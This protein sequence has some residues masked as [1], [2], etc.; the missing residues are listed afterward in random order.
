MICGLS[1]V[2]L[3]AGAFTDVPAGSTYAQAV[4][5]LQDRGLMGG[6]GA[7]Q[8]AP[9]AP[10]TLAEL[11]T[12]LGRIA[13]ADPTERDLPQ[14]IQADGWSGGYMAWA[15]D[16]HLVS[17]DRIGQY[18]ALS[19]PELDGILSAF[20]SMQGRNRVN[21]SAAGS[22]V[23]RG[24]AA[25]ALAQLVGYPAP[26]SISLESVFLPAGELVGYR[27][28]S[29][30][31]FKGIPYATAERFQS[32]EPV[33]A[34]DGGRKM[35]LAFG[36]V[37]PQ[38]ATRNGTASVNGVEI[39]TPSNDTADMVANETCQY[40]N[41]WTDD[42]TANKP[43]VVFFHGGGY[44]SGASSELS[45]YT[46]EYFAGVEDAVFVS[47]NH[48]PNVLG[49]LD[50]SEYG[51][52]Y[53]RSTVAGLEDCV[54]ALQW[55]HDNIAQF[56][57]DPNNVTIVGQ[58]GGGGKVNALAC[59]PETAELFDKVVCMSG[60]YTFSDA[61]STRAAT[62]RLVE[63]LGL[64]EDEVIPTLTSMTY[65][66]LSAACS[67]A[68]I[69][70]SPSYGNSLFPAPLLNE[71]GTLNE[72]AA[73]RQWMIG[74]VYGDHSGSNGP[75]LQRGQED[76]YLPDISDEEAMERLTERYGDNAQE[77]ARLWQAAYPGHQLAEALFINTTDSWG[78]GRLIS[79]TDYGE[80][81]LK[82]FSDNGVDVYNYL[83]AY[84]MPLFGGVT[85][86]HTTDM[87]FWF[88]TL[89]EVD[90]M[91]RGD[92]ANA[93]RVSRQMAD[94][95]AAFAATGDPSTPSL[96]WTP[97]TNASH[98]TMVFDVNSECKTAY[99]EAFENLLLA[100]LPD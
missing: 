10:I 71:D 15:A 59:M 91:V 90:Y 7:G 1:P 23:T 6:R 40:L 14:G 92:E 9:S 27:E 31:N 75:A 48:R 12:V 57:G 67:A 39:L 47:V 58:S 76:R 20:C 56:G 87:G 17:L 73:R 2:S 16:N 26:E 51:E 93:C 63:S 36:P 85:M 8:F 96:E 5:T 69:G 46:G 86:A 70:G 95:L 62:Q 97:Y 11:V 24:E 65:D 79:A 88:Y 33:T 82:T 25:V 61:A 60:M 34:Y 81:L 32:P 64:S 29:V 52:A 45:T 68:G 53:E 21:A 55:V 50:L 42:L 77:L 66:E 83:V 4:Q 35:A 89:D 100:S 74:T 54:C 80:P 84:R 22:Q 38:N 37:S 28:G 94:A 3:A 43:V 78:R 44:S 13:S 41:V 72:Y 18:D 49:F 30:Y 19:M 99:D 98:D